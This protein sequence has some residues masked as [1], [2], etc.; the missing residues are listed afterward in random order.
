MQNWRHS[1]KFSRA[2]NFG[3]S[4]KSRLLKKPPDRFHRGGTCIF[5][6]TSILQLPLDQNGP[7]GLCFQSEVRG[8]FD[9]GAAGG[10][11]SLSSTCRARNPP[12][13]RFSTSGKRSDP[14]SPTPADRAQKEASGPES[15]A[16]RPGLTTPRASKPDPPEPPGGKTGGKTGA[17]VERERYRGSGGGENQE[18]RHKNTTERRRCFWFIS[19]N[20]QMCWPVCS[21]CIVWACPAAA[22][23]RHQLHAD[24]SSGP[25]Q[26]NV[27]L[28][29]NKNTELFSQTTKY[30]TSGGS[31]K[32]I[33][34]EAT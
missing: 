34:P 28:H 15:S 20:I 32:I 22:F 6:N 8:H 16:G 33:K 7:R 5:H 23:W 29:W 10:F 31:S 17:T 1:N 9:P 19:L 27:F 14:R 2:G 4:E 3:G 13:P 11:K 30:F 24:R 21:C 25:E 18:S 26:Q 12:R